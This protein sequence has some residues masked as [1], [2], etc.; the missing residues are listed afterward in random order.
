MSRVLVTG[1]SG[2]VGRHALPL[3]AARGHE[4]HAVSSRGAPPGLEEL[5]TWHRVDL[6]DPGGP[7][8]AIDAVG[9]DLLLH[10]A[11]YAEHGRFWT[12]PEN[13][14]WL[15]AGE[16]L[17]FAFADAGGTRAVV[18][19]TCA[20]Y[21]WSGDG[22]RSE[23]STP[24]APATPYGEAKHALYERARAL[25]PSLGWGRI[26]FLYGPHEDGRRLVASVIR[27]LLAGEPAAT[28]A[29]TQVRDFMHVEDVARALVELLD[30]HVEGA[31]NIGS[32]EATTIADVVTR[33][34]ELAGRPDL[35]RLGE[36]PT[37]PGD[38]P[39]LLADT[40]RLHNEVGFTPALSLDEGLRQTV[41][42]WR[43]R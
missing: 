34:A 21:D 42:W 31:V 18:S 12:A 33:T 16:R 35:L 13:T 15:A 8:A 37:R 17:L 26:F 32:G 40:K 24:L 7:H 1:A 9:P 6:L 22:P 3:L 30:S 11:W 27:T 36:L 39:V 5:A 14:S 41:E 20:E 23:E 38:P 4:V 2:F 43:A 29:G 28:S 19:G 25:V 10:L